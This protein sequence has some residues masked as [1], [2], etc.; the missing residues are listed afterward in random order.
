MSLRFTVLASGSAGN[1]SYIESGGFGLL[2]DI[3]LGPRQLAGRLSAV[4]TSWDR[5]QAVLLT[6][7]HGDH[8]RDRT[9]THLR[10]RR[11]PLYCHD[12]H[13][14]E[15]GTV[16]AEF[17]ELRAEGLVR[18]YEKGREISLSPGLRCRPL[19]LRHDSEPTFGFRLET[20]PDLSGRSSALAYAADLGSW[21]PELVPL[22]AD[23]DA[24]ALEFNHDVALQYASGRPFHLVR[25]ILGDYGHL[26]N[27]QAAGL[28]QEI[29]SCSPPG[30]LRHLV[31]LHLSRDCNRPA[32][33]QRA[34]RTALA[35]HEVEI[36]TASQD[37]PILAVSLGARGECKAPRRG[38]VSR[39]RSRAVSAS[40]RWLPGMEH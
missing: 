35:D 4:G 37:V 17:A 31:Q 38:G 11:I 34:A 19:A 30:R 14:A 24:L 16:S 29:L 18:S 20:P 40:H 15:L 39:G 25:R 33:A 36:H 7:T 2:L 26:S 28:V 5:V 9:L 22:L 6:H 27:V 1:A 32:L 12:A 21:P 23:V 10:R 13:H 8:W 3:G